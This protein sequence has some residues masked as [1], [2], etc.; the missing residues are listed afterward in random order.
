MYDFVEGLAAGIPSL[1][2]H[3]VILARIYYCII[4]D[5]D[6]RCKEKSAKNIDFSRVP[7]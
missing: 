1:M 2:R 6:S 3:A 7:A 5:Q 4:R